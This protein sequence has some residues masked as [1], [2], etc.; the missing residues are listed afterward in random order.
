MAKVRGLIN[1]LVPIKKGS[2]I[3]ILILLF[4]NS[5]LGQ[6]YERY[7]KL[8]DTTVTSKYLGFEKNITITVP[9]EWQEDLDR[10]F[11]LVI[12]FDRQNQRSHKYILNTIDYLTSNEQMPSAIIISVE[13]GQNRFVETWHKASGVEGLA[14]ENEKFI[15]DELIPLAEEKYSASSYRLLVGHSRYGYFT[16]SLFHS[17]INDLNAVVSL[18]PFF[19]QDNV[20]LTDSIAQLANQSFISKKY[21]RYGIGN[22]Y[23]DDFHKMDSTLKKLNNS[24]IDSKGVLFSEAA[25]NVTPGLTIATTLYEIF[26]EW[27]KIQSKYFSNDQIELEIMNSLEDE[28][29]ANYGSRL[30]FSIGVLNGKGWFFYN[31]EKYDKAIEAWE[32]LIKSYP[33]FSDAHLYIIDAKLK[34]NQ[35]VSQTIENFKKS[36]ASSKIY[37]E[38]KKNELLKELE[39]INN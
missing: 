1:V 2:Q 24:T 34:L 14:L 36:L 16:T 9:F 13:S 38:E 22:D 23:P 27:S 15:F 6:E 25:H 29:I 10:D 30:E 35:D 4:T 7:K 33:N 20:D 8:V 37:S 31:D 18:S 28:I 39:N 3:I 19:E 11:P 12:V 5:L 21:Y 32:L 26:E 17:R